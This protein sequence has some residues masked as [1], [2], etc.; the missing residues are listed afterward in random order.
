VV[1]P[2]PW[3]PILL[4]EETTTGTS[5]GVGTKEFKDVFVDL[6]FSRMPFNISIMKDDKRQFIESIIGEM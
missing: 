4:A 6:G 3:L 1:F 2:L 5:I